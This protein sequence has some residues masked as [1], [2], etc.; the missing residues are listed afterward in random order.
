MIANLIDDPQN[1]YSHFGTFTLSVVMQAVYDYVTSARDD[2]MVRLVED[3]MAYRLSVI[4]QERVMLL[5]AFPFLLKLPDWCWGSKIKRDAR[6][7]ITHVNNMI[8]VPFR[9]I[10]FAHNPESWIA[11]WDGK[12]FEK[13]TVKVEG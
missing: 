7:S 4:T 11:L 12:V 2:P 9:L 1:Y 13:E 6:D 10:S 3:V 5:K 8:N